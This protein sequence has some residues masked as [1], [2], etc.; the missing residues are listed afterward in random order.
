M[1]D[2]W[3]SAQGIFRVAQASLAMNFT[4][5]FP[6]FI[7]VGANLAT[8]VSFGRA[9]WDADTSGFSILRHAGFTGRAM[10]F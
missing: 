2:F 3:V 5:R 1:R 4:V 7:A 9:F 10:N 8:W 6:G